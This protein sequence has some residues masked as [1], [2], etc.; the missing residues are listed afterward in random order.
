MPGG[1][2]SDDALLLGHKQ[3]LSHSGE[4]KRALWVL[5]DEDTNSSS[6]ALPS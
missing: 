4:D 2:L 3:S 6:R 5:F 1:L